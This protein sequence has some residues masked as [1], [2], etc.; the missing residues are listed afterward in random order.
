MKFSVYNYPIFVIRNHSKEPDLNLVYDGSPS[1][2]VGKDV[3]EY[4]PAMKKKGRVIQTT[5][6]SWYWD[7]SRSYPPI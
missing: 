5:A 4:R 1:M 2:V 3:R 7:W 6:P